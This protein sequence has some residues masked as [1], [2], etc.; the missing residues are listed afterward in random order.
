MS[1]SVKFIFLKFDEHEK[2][3][4]KR[5]ARIVELEI[6]VG[7]L[8]TKVE[9]LRIK[10]YSRH[11]LMLLHGLPEIKGGD[12]DSLVIEIMKEKMGL[13]ISSTDIGRTHRIN[14]PY[15]IR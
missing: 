5:E 12:T 6:K 13:D 9:K 3:T 10:Q 2:E 7:S 15:I 14:A 11:N 1:N 4:I 8:S